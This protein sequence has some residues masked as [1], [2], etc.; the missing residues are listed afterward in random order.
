MRHGCWIFLVHCPLDFFFKFFMDL[1]LWS[2]C[3]NQ[4][5][6]R[7]QNCTWGSNEFVIKWKVDT[8]NMLHFRRPIK[9]FIL[10]HCVF[11][12]SWWM[13]DHL[14]LHCLVTLGVWHK[15]FG[16]AVITWKPMKQWGWHDDYCPLGCFGLYLKKELGGRLMMSSSRTK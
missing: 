14:F 8:N 5:H 15:L 11:C 2:V 1:I 9:T 7:I 12:L 3:F 16:F 10:E 6:L 13:G 4:F